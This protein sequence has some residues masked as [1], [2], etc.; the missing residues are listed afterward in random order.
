MLFH[1]NNFPGITELPQIVPGEIETP[2][3]REISLLLR[4][5]GVDIT[6]DMELLNFLRKISSMPQLDQN[7]FDEIYVAQAD[8]KDEQARA[9][10]QNKANPK[11]PG[12]KPTAKE[13]KEAHDNKANDSV[14]AI[15]NNIDQQNTDKYT[16][17]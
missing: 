6:K 15:G 4:A 8:L 7:T 11:V 17:Q 9:A 3:L 10:I 12:Q 16:G 5:M 2:D 13:S 1:Y 14:S